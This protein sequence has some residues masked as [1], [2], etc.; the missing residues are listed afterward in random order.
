MGI[1]PAGDPLYRGYRYFTGRLKFPPS[2]PIRPVEVVM[3]D[4]V[5][6]VCPDCRSALLEPHPE[7]RRYEKCPVCGYTRKVF[8]RGV[9]SPG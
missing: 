6:Y 4:L 3:V 8:I 7:D 2:L 1:E 9:Y 5:D